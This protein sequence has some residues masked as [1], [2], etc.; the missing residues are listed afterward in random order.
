MRFTD[1]DGMWPDGGPG[2]DPFFAARFVKTVMQDITI[3]VYNTVTW[4]GSMA[5]PVYNPVRS[6]A[7]K[8]Q[9]DDGYYQVEKTLA[10]E[11]PGQRL[12]GVLDPIGV[13]GTFAGGGPAAFMAKSA[14]GTSITQSIK[15]LRN[16]A[17]TKAWK[18]EQTLIE[19]TGEGTRQWGRLEKAQLLEEGK[20]DGY[21]GHHINNVKDHPDMAGNP[22]NV[23]FV[24][25]GKEEHLP[26]HSGNYQNKTTG[27]LVDRTIKKKIDE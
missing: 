27:D 12:A 6:I 26:K 7:T 19:E 10:I 15:S 16:S 20:V 4:L 17:V 22:N 24:K 1:P 11:S 21:V 13:V 5:Q 8:V 2:D 9:G 14:S 25:A 3:G 18:Q 23:E